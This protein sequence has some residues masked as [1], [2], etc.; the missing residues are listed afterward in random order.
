MLLLQHCRENAA[1]L[2]WNPLLL[3]NGLIIRVFY[4]RGRVVFSF[5]S[6][7]F[8]FRRRHN[9]TNLWN[10]TTSSPQFKCNLSIWYVDALEIDFWHTE[11]SN[12][13][14]CH[15]SEDHF[16]GK[17]QR[18]VQYVHH[19]EP[20]LWWSSLFNKVSLCADALWVKSDVRLSVETSFFSSWHEHRINPDMPKEFTQPLI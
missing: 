18:S 11:Y 19:P 12:A 8:V 13:P 7:K 9:R 15:T 14:C 6:N 10:Q 20:R 5:L 1:Q 2:L 3:G 17:H 16:P 4:I